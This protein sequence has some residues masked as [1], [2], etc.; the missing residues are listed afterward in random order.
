MNN[1]IFPTKFLVLDLESI[2]QRLMHPEDGLGWNS[3]QASRA[4]E[5]YK[6]FLCLI[7]LYPNQAIVPTREIDI[8]WHFH[9]LDTCKYAEDCERLFGYY[10]HHNPNFIAEDEVDNLVFVEG[11]NNT[12]ALFAE[13]FGIRLTEENN[14]LQQASACVDPK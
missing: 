2:A 8:V 11:F 5:R 6:M 12:V 7:Y 14:Q 13:C 3:Q 9:I 10:L 4:I 1:S